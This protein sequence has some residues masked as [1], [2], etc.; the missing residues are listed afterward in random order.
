MSVIQTLVAA[1]F[2]KRNAMTHAK[3]ELAL[4]VFSF[5]CA[6]LGILFLALALYQYIESLYAPDIAALISS[7]IVFAAAILAV[8]LSEFLVS[9][10]GPVNK[11]AEEELSENIHVL[12]TEVF[13]ELED[14]IRENPKIS[15][16]VAALAGMLASR[17]LKL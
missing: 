10:K 14:P 1:A 11:S 13:N 16:A 17:H 15:V 8:L 7:T 5:L 6:G 12:I 9:K 3:A 2:Q 4:L